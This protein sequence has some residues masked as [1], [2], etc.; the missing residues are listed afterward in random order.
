MPSALQYKARSEFWY[1][2][3]LTINLGGRGV[4]IIFGRA[5][6]GSELNLPLLA[7]GALHNISLCEA[8]FSTPLLIILAQSL[9][10]K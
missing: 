4:V 3:A 5:G 6:V 1:I 2:Q 8:H 10:C 9:N 7:G